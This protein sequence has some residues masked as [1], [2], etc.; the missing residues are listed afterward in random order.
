MGKTTE[1]G[2]LIDAAAKAALAPLACKRKGQSRLWISDHR[3]WLISVE[4]QPSAWSKGSYLNVGVR[5]LWSAGSGIDLSYR[6]VDFIPFESTEQFA[7]LVGA[8]ATRGAQEV[9]ALRQRFNS[10]ADIRHHLVTGVIRDSWPVYHA[11]VAAGLMGDIVASRAFFK[12]MEAWPTNDYEWEQRLKSDSAKLAG[13]LDDSA[14]FRSA[15]LAN[16]EQRR[17]LIR[18]PPDSRCLDDALGPTVGP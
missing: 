1:H 6:P 12:R 10:F 14:Q 7:P 2:R 5:W 16:I 4:F 11:A 18:L 3:F 8:M 15:V 13:L 9:I 17:A